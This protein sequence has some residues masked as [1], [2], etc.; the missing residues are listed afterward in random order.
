MFFFKMARINVN[1]S[2]HLVLKAIINAENRL[3]NAIRKSIYSGRFPVNIFFNTFDRGL[4]NPH[5]CR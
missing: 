2:D 5:L 3:N 1:L 4:I